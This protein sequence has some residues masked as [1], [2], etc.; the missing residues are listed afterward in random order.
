MIRR[1]KPN[2]MLHILHMANV[3]FYVQT[4]VSHP[5]RMIPTQVSERD[6]ENG[7]GFDEAGKRQRRLSQL[8][9]VNTTDAHGNNAVSEAAGGGQTHIITLL[10]AKGADIN[11][12]VRDT[13]ARRM[14]FRLYK[15]MGSYRV[16]H[17]GVMRVSF[18]S[19]VLFVL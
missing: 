6:T 8:R 17:K 12:R 7:V 11:A 3:S 4:P 5:I 15:Y 16:A 2:S 13:L 1:K 14:Q 18:F 10:A 19:L 9:T